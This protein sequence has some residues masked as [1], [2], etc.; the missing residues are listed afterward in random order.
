MAAP[1]GGSPHSSGS[2]SFYILL[3]LAAGDRHGYAIGKDVEEHTDGAV[4]LGP[5]TLYRILKQMTADGWIVDLALP[6]DERERRRTYR[7]TPRGRAIARE[8]AR[9]LDALVEVARSRRLLPAL[10]RG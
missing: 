10:V 6:D 8:E 2:A 4:R 7:L 3:A 9:R 1:S 5:G